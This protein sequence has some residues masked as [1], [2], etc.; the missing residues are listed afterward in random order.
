[1]IWNKEEEY[2]VPRSELELSKITSMIFDWLD[3]PNL[4][5]AN[6]VDC[7]Q[8]DTKDLS[9]LF[10]DTSHLPGGKVAAV[11]NSLATAQDPV[12]GT[13]E[14]EADLALAS[15][16]PLLPKVVRPWRWWMLMLMP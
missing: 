7:P 13:V 2:P 14:D 12:A 6:M 15:W 5:L 9:I 3:Y 1:M 10:F 11:D 8:I 16:L 4:A